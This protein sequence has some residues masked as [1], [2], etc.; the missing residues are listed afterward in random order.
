VTFSPSCVGTR[1][2]AL[3]INYESPDE[4]WL[5]L[6][7]TG[8]GA[9]TVAVAPDPSGKF[10]QFAYVANANTNS[11]SMYRIARDTGTL[12][13]L[14]PASIAAGTTPSS[15]AVDPSGKFAYVANASSKDISSYRI[16]A[17]G[18]LASVGS[19]WATGVLPTSVAVAPDPTGAFGGFVYVAN[20]KSYN[21][22]MFTIESGTG[23]LTPSGTIDV[24]TQ[25]WF[26]AVHPTGKF[27]YVGS[28]EGF[29]AELDYLYQN[30]SIYTY[31]ID[32]TTGSLTLK[33][34][35][36]SGENG[37]T[38]L[39]VDPSG[40]FVALTNEWGVVLWWSIDPTAGVPLVPGGGL[41]GRA[42]T[43]ALTVAP[44]GEL[45]AHVTTCGVGSNEVLT[46]AIGAG[47][48]ASSL[49]GTTDAGVSPTSIA[50]D[51]SGRFAYVANSGSG[52]V[53]MYSVNGDGT[54]TPL[55]T[56]GP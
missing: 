52:S 54:L 39:T 22:S 19:W 10:G 51:P 11:V 28:P 7:G 45:V 23:A 43:A 38:S 1:Y 40:K 33:R 21:V 48:W 31:T 56:I 5:P 35:Q 14:V 4:L 46:Y 29:S 2:N 17:D 13:P 44:S 16:G 6:D 15:I 20:V 36:S 27:A 24:G 37:P 30:S 55:G 32:A 12:T 50:I 3:L 9:L 25:P 49:V 47:T 8:I 53:S 41:G 34:L 26:V 18:T 42:A